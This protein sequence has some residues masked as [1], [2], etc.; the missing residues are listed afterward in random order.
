MGSETLRRAWHDAVDPAMVLTVEAI[1]AQPE[2][3]EPRL[4]VIGASIAAGEA[5]APEQERQLRDAVREMCVVRQSE[6]VPL[7]DWLGYGRPLWAAAVA[8]RAGRTAPAPPDFAAVDEHLPFAMLWTTRMHRHGFRRHSVEVARELLEHWATSNVEK[9]PNL[10]GAA[11]YVG[12]SSTY[13]GRGRAARLLAVNTIMDERDY[14]VR[15]LVGLN[16]VKRRKQLNM[17]QEELAQILGMPRG[18]LSK[19]ETGKHKPS[20]RNLRRL[21]DTLE[22]PI[23]YFFADHREGNG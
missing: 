14:S 2:R 8:G 10:R 3:V 11:S 15:E 7:L 1:A 4:L 22:V 17:L 6:N 19:W 23:A 12:T 5:L 16:I 9:L 21:A 13:V 20:D 18:D